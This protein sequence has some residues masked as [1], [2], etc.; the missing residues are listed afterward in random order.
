MKV[1]DS[2]KTLAIKKAPPLDPNKIPKGMT[3]AHWLKGWLSQFKTE[4]DRK[5]GEFC[6][7]YKFY[8]VQCLWT[9]S[10]ESCI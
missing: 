1:D 6:K 2:K 9:G 10:I 7:P 8:N 3:G 5:Y 4:F